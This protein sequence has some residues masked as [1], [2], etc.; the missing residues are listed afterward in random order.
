MTH[1]DV[2]EGKLTSKQKF[3]LIIY[4]LY[5]NATLALLSTKPGEQCDVSP[6]IHF[7]TLSTK[8]RFASFQHDPRRENVAGT[9]EEEKGR[10]DC[11][12]AARGHRIPT[13]VFTRTPN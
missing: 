4:S 6:C 10:E 9:E 13:T 5:R 12:G 3:S 1:Q 11:T 7:R 8:Y 2:P